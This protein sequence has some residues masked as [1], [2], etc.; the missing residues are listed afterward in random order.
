M[1]ENSYTRHSA[2]GVESKIILFWFVPA[3]YIFQ[4][5]VYMV[6]Q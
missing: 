6:W 2:F 5:E 1:L 4:S 3:F